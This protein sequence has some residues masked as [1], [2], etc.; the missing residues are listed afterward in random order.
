MAQGFI[1]FRV[2]SL[3]L[4]FG[5]LAI[6]CGAKSDD[7]SAGDEQA[8]SLPI[9]APP[10][11]G[12]FP[13]GQEPQPSADP[14][15]PLVDPS[16]AS[17][18]CGDSF[19]ACGGLLAGRWAVEGVC[20]GEPLDRAAKQ[21][22]ARSLM[23]LDAEACADAVQAV[24]SRWGGE[25]RFDQGMAIDLRRRSDTA[26]VSLTRSCLSKTFDFSIPANRLDVVCSSLTSDSVSCATGEDACQCTVQRERL[27]PAPGVYGVLE[28]GGVSIGTPTG[29]HD[30]FD[31]CV[32]G[33]VMQWQEPET[34]QLLM[35]RLQSPPF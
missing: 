16:T 13:M 8:P 14:N 5:A 3:A 17:A 30:V 2:S 32:T 21:R 1:G 23:G 24:D 12:Y 18:L 28:Q 33:D 6:G 29:G 7:G 35:L 10:P 25:L 20:A 9:S 26:Q 22:L 27:A 15:T 19:Q 34:G 11:G 31:Y 4:A